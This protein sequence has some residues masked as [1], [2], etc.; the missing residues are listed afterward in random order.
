VPSGFN[1]YLDDYIDKGKIPFAEVACFKRI[2]ND[3][4]WQ[5][6]PWKDITHIEY[7]KKGDWHANGLVY[8]KIYHPEHKPI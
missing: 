1:K 4:Q 6:V 3:N 5:Q 2:S 7:N 8:G